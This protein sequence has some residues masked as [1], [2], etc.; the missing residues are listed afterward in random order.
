MNKIIISCE[1]G[2]NKIPK[3]FKYLFKKNYKILNTHKGYD[4]GALELSQ[5]IFKEIG[6][7]YFYSK[8]SR[9]LIELNRSLNNKNL[10]SSFT[11]DLSS[12]TKDKIVNKYYSPYRMEIENTISD[13]IQSKIKVIHFSIHTFTPVINGKK[14]NADI[15]FLYDPSRDTEQKLCKKFKNSFKYKCSNLSVRL[16]YPYLGIS[17]GFTTYLRKRFEDNYAGIEIEVNQK[18]FLKNNYNDLYN[19]IVNNIKQN[20]I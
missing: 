1:H 14:R 8:T 20:I 17:D 18:Y 12:E 15:G 13:L 10:F 19:C 4:P 9:L 2:G 5:M 3:E 7:Y 6:D 11:R 16:N